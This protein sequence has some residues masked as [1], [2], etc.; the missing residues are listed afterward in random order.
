M[1]KIQ[2]LEL[3]EAEESN[4]RISKIKEDL[5]NFFDQVKEVKK[6]TKS[7]DKNS[8]ISSLTKQLDLYQK[9]SNSMKNLIVELKK[10]ESEN[11]IKLY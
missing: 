5:K 9:I 3:F 8:E 7:G 4:P 10:P 11:K 2:S 1:F 6:T